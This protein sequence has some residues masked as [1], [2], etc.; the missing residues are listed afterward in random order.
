ML[1]QVPSNHAN[2]AQIYNAKMDTGCTCAMGSTLA[3]SSTVQ[4]D[5][6][7]FHFTTYTQGI[8]LEGHEEL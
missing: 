5:K 8:D 1:L 6:C 7:E 4:Y 3:V 2:I